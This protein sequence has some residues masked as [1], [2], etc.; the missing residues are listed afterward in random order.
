[1]IF[2]TTEYVAYQN[3]DHR[4]PAGYGNLK[5]KLPY[6]AGRFLFVERRTM[7]GQRY[8]FTMDAYLASFLIIKNHDYEIV[9]NGFNRYAFRF[10]TS[11][12]LLQDVRRYNAGEQIETIKFVSTIKN[13]KGQLFSKKGNEYGRSGS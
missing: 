7:E 2:S 4:R 9:Q 3:E 11:D 13:L 8:Y 6:L 5:G 12:E 10:L 1:M